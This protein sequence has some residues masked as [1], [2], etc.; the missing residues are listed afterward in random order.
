LRPALVSGQRA[1]RLRNIWL[2]LARV[3]VLACA[4]LL[5]AGPTCAPLPA[6]PDVRQPAAGVLVV[7]DSWSMQYALEDGTTLVQ[8]ARTEALEFTRIA[9]QWP[10]PSALALVWSDPDRP[11][12][13]LTTDHATIRA[14]LREAHTPRPH[15]VPLGHALREAARLLQSA[16]QPERR[17]VVFTDQAGHAWRNVTPGLLAG[18][19]NLGV[20][21]RSVCPLRRTNLALVASGGPRSRHPES[22]PVPLEATVS[23]TGLDARV[24]LVVREAGRVVDRVGP[25][26]LSADAMRD[27]SLMLPPHPRGVH[28]LEVTVEPDD[29]LSF[30]QT[31]YVVFQTVERPMAWLVT[32]P[33]AGPDQDLTALLMRNL[34][35]PETLPD[36]RQLVAFRHV[37]TSGLAELTLPE[38]STD[39]PSAAEARSDLIVVTSGGELN[40]AA[41]QRLRRCAERGATILLLPGSRD[42]TT[43]WPGLRRLLARSVVRVET[44]DAVTSLAWE[45]SSAFAGLGAAVDELTRVAVR[46]RVVLGG[47]ENGVAVEARYTDGVPAIVSLRRGRGRL[48][49]LTTSPDPQWSEFGTRAAGLLSWLHVLLQQ[50]LGSPDAVA[51]F[52]TGEATRRSF[53]RLPSGGVARVASSVDEKSRLA[54]VRL[55]NGEPTRGW[56]TEWPGVYAVRAGR[57][58]TPEALYAV[59]WPAEESDL[60]PIAVDRLSALLGV[61]SVTIEREQPGAGGTGPTLLSRLTE[62]GDIARMLPFVLLALMLGETLVA[63]RGRRSA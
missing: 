46:R 52:T 51:T 56:P 49:L 12:T 4:A 57:E 20:T 43:D 54:S 38:P 36:E 19:D 42:D 16:R 11:V 26:E 17:L 41:R 47:F 44:V 24:H 27:V 14:S 34:L 31:R 53:A 25:L 55:S 39:L 6:P 48:V 5:L 33:E 37:T 29:R 63:A 40:E 59:N 18:I 2:L 61:E 60:R 23:A 32:P 22:M 15:A 7:D 58:D 62:W 50:A 1:Q 13:E 9:E 28:A 30:D 10:Q 3:L 21:V 35:A 45:S 8:R